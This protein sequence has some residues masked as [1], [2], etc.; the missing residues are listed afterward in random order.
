MSGSSFVAGVLAYAFTTF[1]GGYSWHLV[2]F[3][4]SYKSLKVW[5]NSDNPIIAFGVGAILLQV[6]H[7][8]A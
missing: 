4:E 5:T 7:V 2:A 3:L 1:A 8:R 6:M